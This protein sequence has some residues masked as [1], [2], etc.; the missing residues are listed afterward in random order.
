MKYNKLKCKQNIGTY[1]VDTSICF[2]KELFKHKDL[3]RLKVKGLRNIHHANMNQK[4]LEL[5]Y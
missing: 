4:N 2:Q 1:F 3:N 5:L